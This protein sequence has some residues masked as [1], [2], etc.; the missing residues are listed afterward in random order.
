M[1]DQVFILVGGKG[2]RLGNVTKKNPKPL[3]KVNKKPFLDYLISFFIKFN[4]REIILLTNYQ[5]KK[6][7][8]KY[9]KK[10]IRNTRIICLNEDE[11]LGTSGSL[12]NSL[13]QAKKQ[14][15]LCNGDTFFDINLFD[16]IKKFDNNKVC[17]LAC[18]SSQKNLKRYSSFSHK[19]NKYV[20]SG[21]YLFNKK[22][23]KKFLIEKGSL[24]NEVLKKIPKK[25]IK[26]VK[27]KKKFIDIGTPKDLKKA[28]KF[29]KSCF[30][31]KCSFLDRDG[32]IN[33]DLGYVHKRKNFFWKK[34]VIKTIKY[35][36]DNNYYV[37]VISNQSGIGRGLYKEEDVEKLHTWINQEL[38]KKGAY[39]DK[40]Y[41]APYYEYS[42]NKKYTK[43]KKNRKPN[44]GMFL[45]AFYEFDIIKKSSFYVG[46]KDIDKIAAKNFGIKYLN[47]NNNSD[48][49]NVLLS[50]KK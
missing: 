4:F 28:N 6:F 27:Y 18:S 7:F 9:N 37:I 24:E 26:F 13:G 35:L 14:F 48:I 8:K 45:R 16:F 49:Y 20:S 40:F 19:N 23:I 42:K 21:I 36:N 29:L 46:D 12:K 38:S 44:I 30:R 25:D 5:S 32:V 39:I 11:Y 50:R 47:V 43:G 34:N 22:K 3:I 10:Y 33:Y 2:S 17:S 15:M 41:Y 31:K 1:V